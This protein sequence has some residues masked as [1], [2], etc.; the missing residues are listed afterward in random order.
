MGAAGAAVGQ[1][2]QGARAQ[3]CPRGVLGTTT[4]RA[5]VVV[6]H[7]FVVWMISRG[8]I[9]FKCVET[10]LLSVASCPSVAIPPSFRRLFHYFERHFRKPYT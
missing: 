4:S 10:L 7:D 2:R 5:D 9:D 1:G 8:D 3:G 6:D